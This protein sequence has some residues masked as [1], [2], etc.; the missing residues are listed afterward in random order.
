M[1]KTLILAALFATA[2]AAASPA[3]IQAAEACDLKDEIAALAAVQANTSFSESQQLNAEV[4]ARRK[5]FAAAI[6]CD[7]AEIDARKE[8]LNRLP[9]HMKSLKGHR[10]ILESLD[11]NYEYYERREANIRSLDLQNLK[12]LSRSLAGWRKETHLPIIT[13][14]DNFL[15]W[16]DSQQLL[17]R[18]SE[19]LTQMSRIAFSLKLVNQD[20]I[21]NLF[22]K[23]KA[24]FNIAS[25]E[26]DKAR[27]A[28]DQKRPE[29]ALADTQA[30]LKAL[31]DTYDAFFALQEALKNIVK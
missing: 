29:G 18:A 3:P 10:D 13:W 27:N 11:S 2:L 1:N 16:A 31:A 7:Q 23:A 25:V 17:E 12:S 30:S 19:R 22:E 20:E 6:D 9:D 28:L 24:S 26:N 8:A 15:I 4:A 21:T 14:A 5:L